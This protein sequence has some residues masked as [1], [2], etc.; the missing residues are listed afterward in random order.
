MN[1]ELVPLLGAWL[2]PFWG[3]RERGRRKE[4]QILF[5]FCSARHCSNEFGT[6]LAYRKNSEFQISEF[7]IQ[8]LGT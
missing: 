1:Y 5:D 6:A 7:Q 4:F 8:Q 2:S 3:K